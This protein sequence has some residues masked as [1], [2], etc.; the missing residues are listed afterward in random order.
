MK[1]NK[2]IEEFKKAVEPLNEILKDY[3]T[4]SEI[5]K[6]EEDQIKNYTKLLRL[7]K[8]VNKVLQDMNTNNFKIDMIRREIL[9]NYESTKQNTK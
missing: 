7:R 9:H 6:L 8:E 5:L 2:L 4:E 1:E 3:Y